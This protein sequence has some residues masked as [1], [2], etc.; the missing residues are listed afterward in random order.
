MQSQPEVQKEVIREGTGPGA[1][2]GDTVYVHYTGTL[3]DGSKFDSSVDRGVPFS[4]VL[5]SGMVIQGWDI[6]V[7]G[8]QVGEKV[9]LTIPPELGY[10]PLGY[11]PVIPENATLRFEIE[12][13]R[14]NPAA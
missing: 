8:M 13:I 12:L 7:A 6:G 11:P 3:V 5:G 1:K 2:P 4:F 14:L 10:G 9:R